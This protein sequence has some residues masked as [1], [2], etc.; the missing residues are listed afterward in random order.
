LPG[1][2]I[3]LDCAADDAE[4]VRQPSHCHTGDGQK[5]ETAIKEAGIKGRAVFYFESRSACVFR[6][7]YLSFRFA[8]I[9]RSNAT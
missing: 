6:K 4:L 9:K 7:L 2:R 5:L 3:C 1:K 8:I